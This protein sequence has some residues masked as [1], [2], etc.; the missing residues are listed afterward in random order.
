MWI[1]ADY[2]LDSGSAWSAVR[3]GPLEIVPP[4][5]FSADGRRLGARQQA[6]RSVVRR[7]FDRLLPE[8]FEVR[9]VSLP[10]AWRKRGSLLIRH[11]GA[12]EGWLVL[13]AV[14]AAKQPSAGAPAPRKGSPS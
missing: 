3:S 13:D 9:E 6:M 2:T 4:G 7:R 11:A 12:A 1:G 14:W 5:F 10:E 8:R